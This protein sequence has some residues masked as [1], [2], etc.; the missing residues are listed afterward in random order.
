MDKLG[1]QI[2]EKLG[3]GGLRLS[4]TNNFS[5]SPLLQCVSS[6]SEVACGKDKAPTIDNDPASTLFLAYR[7]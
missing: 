7:S 2:P 4:F 3:Y 1:E 6:R 5:A